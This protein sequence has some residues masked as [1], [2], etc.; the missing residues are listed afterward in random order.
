MV[1][2]VAVAT[3]TPLPL[4][5]VY[6]I[7]QVRKCRRKAAHKKFDIPIENNDEQTLSGSTSTSYNSNSVLA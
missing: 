7:I 6:I 1:V 3:M 2:P 4:L 5:V